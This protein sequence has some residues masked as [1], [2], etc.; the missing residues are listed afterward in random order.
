MP[1]YTP[2]PEI[3]HELMG[4]APMFGDP[5]FA[6]FYHQ[7]GLASLGA[8]D[9]DIMRLATCYWFSVEFGLC[10]EKHMVLVYYLVLVNWNIHVHHIAQLVVRMTGQKSG[11]GYQ[12]KLQCKNIQLQHINQFIIVLKVWKMQK[13]K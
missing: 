10:Y 2:E 6:E 12:N 1:L 3:C 13:I 5:K 7:I 11:H 4:H 9:T 8:S